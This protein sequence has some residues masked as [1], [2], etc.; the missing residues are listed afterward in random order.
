[1]TLLLDVLVLQC[2]KSPN[3]TDTIPVLDSENKQIVFSYEL[4]L[5]IIYVKSIH[6][7]DIYDKKCTTMYRDDRPQGVQTGKNQ[8]LSKFLTLSK[9][10]LKRIEKKING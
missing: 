8:M 3:R 10:H 4:I 1:M 5:M 2:I 6:S 7:S 9:W